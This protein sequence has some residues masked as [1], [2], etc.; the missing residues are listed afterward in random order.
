MELLVA[1]DERWIRTGIIAKLKKNGI[2]FDVIYE[3]DNGREALRLILEKNPDMVFLDIKMPLMNGIEVLKA[4]KNGVVSS[5]IIIVSGLADFEMVQT[6]VNLGVC[7]Y[8]LK[9][10]VIEK[11]LDITQKMLNETRYEQSLKGLAN[12]SDNLEAANRRLILEKGLN[13]LLHLSPQHEVLDRITAKYLKKGEQA[14]FILLHVDNCNVFNNNFQFHNM[15]EC[16]NSIQS[17]VQIVLGKNT[18]IFENLLNTFEIVIMIKND[19]LKSFESSRELIPQKIHRIIRQ[20][21]NISLTIAVSDITSNISHTVYKQL[22]ITS[23]MRFISGNNR[24]YYFDPVCRS[25]MSREYESYIHMFTT[26]LRTGDLKDAGKSLKALFSAL[27]DS[28]I[29]P[30]TFENIFDSVLEVIGKEVE[31]DKPGCGTDSPKLFENMLDY[32][33]NRDEAFEYIYSLVVQLN[34]KNL[35]AVN[36]TDCKT[37]V[38]N[39]IRYIDNNYNKELKVKDISQIYSLSPNYLSSIF[40]KQAGVSFSSYLNSRRIGEACELLKNTTISIN[41]ISDTVG[42][43]D[44]LYFHKVFK[45]LKGMTPSVYRKKEIIP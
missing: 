4:L 13:Y 18:F 15:E 6:A 25:N 19:S 24:V 20:E 21:F 28:R 2:I 32:L 34:E 30:F 1:D 11:L 40:K 26:S 22:R 42:F 17:A 35:S 23:N 14:Y 33:D 5:R 9:P 38:S 44:V 37:M 39:I 12:K 31:G 8:L 45:K 7:G 29:T 27:K 3:T 10:I 41:T 36:E 16:K 43:N